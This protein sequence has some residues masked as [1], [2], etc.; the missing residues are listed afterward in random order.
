[1]QNPLP[2]DKEETLEEA[3]SMNMDRLT[4]L[5]DAIDELARMFANSVEYLNR[6]QVHV[7]QDPGKF[8]ESQRELVQDIVKKS[9]Q[10]ELLIEKLPGMQNSEQEQIDMIKEL[11][12]EMHEANLEYLKA[13]LKKQIMETI[14]ILCRDQS[15]AYNTEE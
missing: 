8:R 9:K 5:Q 13:S 12:K 4:Q 11:N 14:G 3:T 6:A 15:T 10:I 2:Y 1:M 7:D